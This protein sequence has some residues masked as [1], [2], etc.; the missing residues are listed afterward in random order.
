M[1]LKTQKILKYIPI[2]NFISVISWLVIGIKRKLGVAYFIKNVVIMG[3]LALLLI[4]LGR[5]VTSLFQSVDIK[6]IIFLICTVFYTYISAFIAV[7]EQESIKNGKY[8]TK[9]D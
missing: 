4:M 9:N 8:D 5:G 7:N 2:V 6:H 3:A 1:W